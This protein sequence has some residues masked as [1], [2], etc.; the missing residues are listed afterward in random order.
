MQRGAGGMALRLARRTTRLGHPSDSNGPLHV[1]LCAVS[2]ADATPAVWQWQAAAVA[3]YLGSESWSRHPR[4]HRVRS[5]RESTT[6][7]FSL[8]LGAHFLVSGFE[9]GRNLKQCEGVEGRGVSEGNCRKLCYRTQSPVVRQQT[10]GRPLQEG[11]TAAMM[12][13]VGNSSY[14]SIGDDAMRT[15]EP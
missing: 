5:P 7:C 4:R 3:S 15:R 11:L 6:T 13:C 1:K 2:R 8:S 9:S 14:V 12:F 10:L